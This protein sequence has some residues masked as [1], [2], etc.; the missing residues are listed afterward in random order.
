MRIGEFA[1]IHNVTHDT[2]RHYMQMGLLVTKKKGSHYNF[3][4][5]DSRDMK[6]ILELRELNFSLSDIQKIL[7]YQRLAGASTA[8]RNHYLSYLEEKEKE[9]I[10]EQKEHEKMLSFL[11]FK[12]N[13][14]KTM[15]GIKSK[16]LGLPM[17]AVELLHCP[18]CGESLSVFGG[19]IEENMII[20]ANIH[21][22]CS[23]NAI[24]KDGIYIDKNAIRKRKLSGEPMPSKKE[25]L[26]KTPTNFINFYYNGMVLIM[27]S[28]NKHGRQAKYIL[29]IENC[30]GSFLM[31]YIKDLP[32]DCTYI[33]SDYDIEKIRTLKEELETY[34]KHRNFIFLCCNLHE[35]PLGNDA[36]DM[37]IEFWYTRIFLV[38]NEEPPLALARK[39]L[40][41]GG[42]VL[43]AYP[44]FINANY[45]MEDT[46]PKIRQYMNR[47]NLLREFKN[48]G[49]KELE[50]SN[51]G[52]IR[53]PSPYAP[54]IDNKEICQ[55]IYTGT[56]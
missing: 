12:I 23:Y 11:K 18:K 22:K 48:L 30:V 6:K 40:K 31:Q 32:E 50:T 20:D 1:K 13:S 42:L 55:L 24:I 36:L 25:Y 26:D 37:I 56:G 15:E 2:I 5:K 3:T 47:E 49:L 33:L 44:Y 54:D 53:E 7:S 45:D 29:E 16:K 39:H 43:G 51:I 14:L 28:I 52:P 41:E 10:R 46:L 17:T 35:L 19:S 9:I 8:Y 4:D 38:E 27:D 21:C 34:H